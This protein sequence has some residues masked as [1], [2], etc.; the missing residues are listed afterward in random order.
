MKVEARWLFTIKYSKNHKAMAPLIQH[1]LFRVRDARLGMRAYTSV[2]VPG[3]RGRQIWDFKISQ[4]YGVSSRTVRATER[5]L[6]LKQQKLNTL[7]LHL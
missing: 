2:P 1:S 3:S 7:Y 4:V 6:A 5:D